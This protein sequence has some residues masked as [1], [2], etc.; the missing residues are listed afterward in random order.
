MTYDYSDDDDDQA[1][2]N[3]PRSDG[4]VFLIVASSRPDLIDPALLRPG[5]IEKH[6]FISMP[7]V[8]DRVAILSNA[9][10]PGHDGEF[11]LDE[12]VMAAIE[13]V[14]RSDK[15]SCMTPADLKA[16]ISTANLIA[17]HEYM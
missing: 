6:I 16:V 17:A 9:L 8:L 2:R 3:E 10:Q 5:R 11:L 12:Q 14:A 1:Q 4:T 7:N 15:A 13:F